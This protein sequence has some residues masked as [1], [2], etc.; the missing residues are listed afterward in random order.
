MSG[1]FNVL[2]TLIMNETKSAYFIHWFAHQLQ[3]ALALMF[4]TK[5]HTKIND[6]FDVVSRLLNI[7][8]WVFLQAT[9]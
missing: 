6:F 1:A 7:I 8:G 5:N 4:A 3:L 2:K 9:R